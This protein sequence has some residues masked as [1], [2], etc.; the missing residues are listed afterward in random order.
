VRPLPELIVD[1]QPAKSG[2]D[3]VLLDGVFPEGSRVKWWLESASQ[4]VL[5]SRSGDVDVLIE[6]KALAAAPL[7][8]SPV[9]AATFSAGR[10]RVLHAMGHFY[11]QKG[12]ISGAMGAQRLAINFIHMRLTRETTPATR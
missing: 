2:K 9:I 12:N 5:V 3:H 7:S 4:D 10:G 6:S 11:Q 1:V 8:R